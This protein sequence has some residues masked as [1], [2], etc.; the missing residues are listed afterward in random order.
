MTYPSGRVLH[1]Q[2]DTAGDITGLSLNDLNGQSVQ[3]AQGIAYEPE[4][5]LSHLTFGNGLSED[6]TYNLNYQPQSITVGNVLNHSYEYSADGNII[7]ARDNLN[8]AYGHVASYDAIDRMV[9]SSGW[10]GVYSFTY[11]ANGNRTSVTRSG[12]KDT[13]SISTS[14]NY[15]TKTSVGAVSYTH[16]AT[17]N[18]TKR[19]S[20]VFAYNGY[21]QL[22]GATVN[23]TVAQYKYDANNQRASKTVA[24]Q[25]TLYIYDNDGRLLAEAEADTC[26]RLATKILDP[27]SQIIQSLF[28]FIIEL[29]IVHLN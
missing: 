4:G 9:Q 19:G 25:T 17:G 3:L 23:G 26:I 2:R 8:P 22:T 15:L 28:N 14:N 13:Y 11:D 7:N 5:P 10:Y 16:D 20:D 21:G 24:G 12:T 6:R 27:S 1:Y 18:I 29:F